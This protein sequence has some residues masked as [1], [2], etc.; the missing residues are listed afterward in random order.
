MTQQQ[1]FYLCSR[2]VRGR[3][4]PQRVWRSN[5]G[6]ALHLLLQETDAVAMKSLLY[7]ESTISSVNTPSEICFLSIPVRNL[8]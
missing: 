7:Q 3:E 8:E 1:R 6:L 5:F 2:K 4:F